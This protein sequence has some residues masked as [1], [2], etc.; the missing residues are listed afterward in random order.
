ME[1]LLHESYLTVSL[2]AEHQWLYANWT[3]EQDMTTVRAGC[4]HLIDLV[5]QKR[6]CKLL[7]DNR[8]VTT[9][10]AEAAEWVGTYCIPELA[11]A[12]LCC[13]AWVYSPYAFSQM[14]TNLT[15]CYAHDALQIAT[16]NSLEEAEGW[17]LACDAERKTG[18]EEK[19]ESA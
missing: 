1:E 18:E 17:L 11:E 9:S 15:I 5:R 8:E 19:G 10:W 2:D 7:N 12:G 13:L 14:A 6:V 16:F 3:G 4:L